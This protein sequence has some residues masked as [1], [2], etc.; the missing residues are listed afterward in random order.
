MTYKEVI[1][2]ARTCMG[3]YCKACPECNGTGSAD[4]VMDT[5]PTCHGKGRITRL[6]QSFFGQMQQI[7]TCPD[8]QGE[9]KTV[10]NK[11]PRCN[12]EG[13]V[14]DEEVITI[15]IPAG[16][17]EGMELT[18]Q[19]KGNAAPRGG[20]PGNLLVLIE[21]EPHAELIRDESDLIYNLLLSVPTAALGGQ[22]EIPTLSGK[23]KVT[24]SPGTQPG[25][26]LRLR[27]KGLPQIDGYGR[28]VG[29][30]DLLVNVGVY[31]P[32]KLTKEEKAWMEKFQQSPNAAPSGGTDKRSFFKNL[33]G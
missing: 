21:E 20:V 16:V 8:C 11:C 24:I 32:E 18:V 30:G 9:G 29:Q 14:R 13:V 2:N 6:R 25:K 23:V 26:V 17:A 22:V 3:P 5:C 19:G 27:G 28:K 1:E 12:G 33:F 10:K 7:E 4:G 31:V 15:Q